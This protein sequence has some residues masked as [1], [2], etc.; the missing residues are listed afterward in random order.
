MRQGTQEGDRMNEEILIIRASEISRRKFMEQVYTDPI[1]NDSIHEWTN[2]Y[3]TF[4]QLLQRVVLRLINEMSKQEI[5]GELA[6]EQIDRQCK[7]IAELKED[8]KRHIAHIGELKSGL[9]E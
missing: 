2:G 1:F 7:E 8:V 9:E 6:I 3:C 4:E 5:N